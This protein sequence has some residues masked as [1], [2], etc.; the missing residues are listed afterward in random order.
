MRRG[1][2]SSQKLW[3]SR[4]SPPLI[5]DYDFYDGTDI[6]VATTCSALPNYDGVIGVPITF[7][8]A[9]P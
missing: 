7:A 4:P 5:D 9:M 1:G 8:K 3:A 6:A 2:L